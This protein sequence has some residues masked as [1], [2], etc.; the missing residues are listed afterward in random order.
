MLVHTK[1]PRGVASIN[2]VR[3]YGKYS[4]M[5]PTDVSFEAY[6]SCKDSLQDATYREGS[7]Q[8]IYDCSFPEVAFTY[9]E[10][11]W[12]PD[13]T[14]DKIGPLMVSEYDNSWSH[15][16][17]VDQIKVSLREKSPCR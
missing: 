4:K 16:K 5:P 2:G 11:R 13:T 15:K 12:L 9:T 1:T 7:L 17:K 8:K 14:L 3:I 10:L 6:S